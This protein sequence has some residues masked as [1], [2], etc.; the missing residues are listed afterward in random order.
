VTSRLQKEETAKKMSAP[1]L[2][3]KHIHFP[4]ETTYI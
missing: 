2:S 3:V 1:A 4:E